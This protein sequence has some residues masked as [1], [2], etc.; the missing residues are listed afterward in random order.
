MIIVSVIVCLSLIVQLRLPFSFTTSYL[1]V[2]DSYFFIDLLVV[3]QHSG[4]VDI[5]LLPNIDR[6]KMLSDISV[7]DRRYETSVKDGSYEMSIKDGSY[8]ASVEDRSYETSVASSSSG[9]N[10]DAAHFVNPD[11]EIV[12]DMASS[13]ADNSSSTSPF[14]LIPSGVP[15]ST[16]TDSSFPFL[17]LTHLVVPINRLLRFIIKHLPG[18]TLSS[19]IEGQ[20]NKR[21]LY[22][23]S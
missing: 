21:Q 20:I 4:S 3:R 17:L 14:V 10:L 22:F 2:Y 6:D 9:D 18:S 19:A 15:T 12:L 1:S 23:F 7:E 11:S 16:F 8:E 13:S 5:G